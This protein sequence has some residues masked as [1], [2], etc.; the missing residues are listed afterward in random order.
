MLAAYSLRVGELTHL[1]ISDMHMGDARF[2]IRSKP[3][4]FWSVK[5]Q[6]ERALPIPEEFRAFFEHRV[7]G[8][9]EGSL[10][11]S[12][13][14]TEGR[15]RPCETFSSSQA[16]TRRLHQVAQQARTQGEDSEREIA[17]AIRPF[18]RAMGQ[19]PEKRIRQEFMKVTRKIGC[20]ELTRAHSL[21]HLFSTRLQEQGVN[22][23]LVQGMLRHSTLD[24][25]RRY[26]HFGMDS[27][28]HAIS[29]VL[30]SDPVFRATVEGNAPQS[31]FEKGKIG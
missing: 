6:R 21:R 19:I 11:L 26:T 8:R 4:M 13:A 12:R 29:E 2:E 27:K 14:F 30:R 24:M 28:R 1:L 22:P 10:F 20:P 15:K 7:N 3:E 17:K 18:L 31:V 16:L 23:L 9:K 5:S 25:T